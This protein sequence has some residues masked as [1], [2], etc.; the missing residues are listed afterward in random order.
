MMNSRIKGL[1]IDV[2]EIE[3]IKDAIKSQGQKFLNRLFTPNEQKYCQ[4]LK[5]D[6]SIRFASRFCAKEAC[7]KAFGT[8]FGKD[9]SFLD[10]EIVNNQLG[11][12]EILLSEPVT[13]RF[14]NPSLPLSM[15]H[16][17]LSA[18]AVVIWET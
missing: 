12:P 4:N 16:S 6:P 5:K 3:R 13:K 7:V 11:K 18:T 14:S 15:S 10:I 1:G 2:I 8:G 9:I 17:K